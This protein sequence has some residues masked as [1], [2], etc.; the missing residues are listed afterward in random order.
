M[1]TVLLT[2]TAIVL[3]NSLAFASPGH[4]CGNVYTY[5]I[6]PVQGNSVS[7]KS[8]NGIYLTDFKNISKEDVITAIQLNSSGLTLCI[9]QNTNGSLAFRNTAE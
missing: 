3:M 8:P 5:Q 1:K 7:I 6:D 9:V 2:L 4:P